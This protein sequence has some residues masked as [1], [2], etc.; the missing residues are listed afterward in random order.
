MPKR[1]LDARSSSSNA[2]RDQPGSSKSINEELWKD[3]TPD[4]ASCIICRSLLIEP[5]V[6]PC[7]CTTR[8]RTPVCRSCLV[9][10]A[11]A[12]KSTCSAECPRCRTRLSVFFRKTSKN[13]YIDA[14]NASLAKAIEEQRERLEDEIENLEAAPI[15]RLIARNG[16]IRQEFDEGQKR[17]RMDFEREKKQEEEENIRSLNQ[18]FS[19]SEIEAQSKLLKKFQPNKALD[20]IS[21]TSKQILADEMIARRMQREWSGPAKF[22]VPNTAGP[23][24]AKRIIAKAKRE[25]L[26][27]NK[28]KDRSVQSKINFFPK[29]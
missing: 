27:R 29:K 8:T 21:P 23:A 1:K 18:I 13:D 12:T 24:E 7:K 6:L 17:A 14:V 5:V 20:S 4:E 11:D 19:R 10:L 25:M 28:T 15:P 22:V 2:N 26:G 16:E 3:L 9:R